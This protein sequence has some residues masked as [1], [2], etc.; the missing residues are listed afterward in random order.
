M[1]IQGTQGSN[2]ITLVGLG[3][4]CDNG[5]L[6]HDSIQGTFSSHTQASIS[7]NES[8]SLVSVAATVNVT[9]ASDGTATTTGTYCIPAPCA[10]VAAPRSL[11]R[12]TNR[13]Y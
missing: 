3:G 4:E 6:G 12:V 11:V 5:T 2:G 13:S 1:D 9:F 7:L 8:G 10:F